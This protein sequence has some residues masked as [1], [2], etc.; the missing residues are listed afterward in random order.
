MKR[1]TWALLG[2]VI[3]LGAMLCANRRAALSASAKQQAVPREAAQTI[4]EPPPQDEGR[5]VPSAAG[6]QDSAV[7]TPARTEHPALKAG[8]VDRSLVSQAVDTLVSPQATYEQKKAAWKQLRESGKLDQAIA[9]LEQRVASD[10][11]SADDAAALGHAYLQKCGMLQDVREQ[12][13]LAMQA[14]KLFDAALSLDP[15]NWEA[16][17]TKAVALSY[18]P[19]TMNKGDEVIQHFQTLVQQQETESPQPQFAETYV[20]L[21]NQYEKA[22]RIDEARATWQRGAQLFPQNES[23]KSK[24]SLAQ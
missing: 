16:R 8:E 21:G 19:A 12:G 18:W 1:L 2:G 13:I 7:L 10:P 14:D 5:A 20:L 23:L 11:R 15:S 6:T 9:D 22:G 17:F 24:L 4:A 3:I